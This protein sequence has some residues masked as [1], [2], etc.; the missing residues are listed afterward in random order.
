MLIQTINPD[1]LYTSEEVTE[2]L[3]VSLRTTQRL[4]K[5]G[6]LQSYKVHGQYRIKGLDLLNYLDDVKRD[7][8]VFEVEK[9]SPEKLIK[10]LEVHPISVELAVEIIPLVDPQQGSNFLSQVEELRKKIIMDLG[11]IFPGIQF[12]DNI[13]LQKNEYNIQ[14]NGV[15]VSKSK[16]FTDKF[17]VISNNE[18]PDT[19]EVVDPV[20]SQKG[21]W[22]DEN[23]KN[24]FSEVLT[25]AEFLLK[26]LEFITKSFSHEIISREEVFTI[27]EKIRK[28]HS[29]VVEEVISEDSSSNEKLSIGKLKNILKEL[30]REQVSIRNIPL[31]LEALADGIQITKDTDVLVEIVRESL[32]RQICS[33]LAD[34]NN[35]IEVLTVSDNIEKLISDSIKKDAS[36]KS[37]YLP[38]TETRKIHLSLKELVKEK[39][40]PI[41]CSPL[42]RKYLR[43]LI[44]RNFY[45]VPVL[46]FR[47]ISS[48]IKIS[49]CG[50]IDIK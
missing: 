29:V 3:R 18:L 16:L 47:E 26:H 15:R 40:R 43:L 33:K 46:S 9:D 39:N 31:I 50:L 2:Y 37:F 12:K 30:L 49:D 22:V 45:Q 1:H 24:Q 13:K 42:I 25:P 35:V 8:E 36:G 32:S 6:L 4:L 34:D 7:A 17:Y 11:F 44:E 14:V 41:I 21:Y 27:V 19:E 48:S 38:A 5:T 28:N 10:M 20:S 23:F